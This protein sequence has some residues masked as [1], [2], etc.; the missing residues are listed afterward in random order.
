MELYEYLVLARERLAAEEGFLPVGGQLPGAL[1]A[2]V[3]AMLHR[4]R[5]GHLGY[6]DL[7]VALIPA[8]G[9][10]PGEQA[11]VVAG[12]RDLAQW[13]S[14][15]PE[16]AG[17]PAVVAVFV[18]PEG[19]DD[20]TLEHLSRLKVYR[21]GGAAV[22]PWA[23]DL[24]ARQLLRHEGLPIISGLAALE[25]FSAVVPGAPS[26]GGEAVMT[27]VYEG[28]PVPY[29]TYGL[30]VLIA[31]AYLW[32]LQ[33]GSAE[34]A[35]NLVRHGA[36][37][38]PS[39]L[40]G[41]EYWRLL[42]SMFL[43][44]GPVHLMG[45]SF[46]LLQMGR[47]V[48]ALFGRWRFGFIYLVGG[49]CGSLVSLAFGEFY[50]PSVG[51][52]GA[53]F[54]LFGAM[55]FFR[56]ASPRGAR[57]PWSGLLWPIAINLSIGLVIP[58]VDNWAHVGGLVGGLLAAVVAGVPARVARWR[59]AAVGSV[60]VAAA[61]LLAGLVP[62]SDRGASLELGRAALN[63]GRLAEA[64]ALLRVAQEL[65]PRD[66][67]PHYYLAQAFARQGRRA[68]ALEQARVARDLHP[69]QPDVQALLTRL[70]Q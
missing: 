10:G 9:L 66:W 12:L 69:G 23:V 60:L 28:P 40:W 24:P 15:R 54:G 53:I 42:T 44:G 22:L 48:E 39:I 36:N 56:A 3:H 61:L 67:R 37:D 62:V 57:M 58:H 59:W 25:N 2:Q 41:G 49:I 30:L 63:A 4:R 46:V 6:A 32:V 14:G 8:G 35:R 33:G 20:A 52:S 17:A 19:V 70:E 7:F 16:A 27:A 31:A 64:E 51:A 11:A 26:G 68:D 47:L 1:G 34:D 50:R 65:S 5:S 55:V 43:H 45:N 29:V 13:F 21:H 18:F 38:P